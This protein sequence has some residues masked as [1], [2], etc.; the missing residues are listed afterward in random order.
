MPF[1]PYAIYGEEMWWTQSDAQDARWEVKTVH[2]L[3]SCP[4]L[5]V[6]WEGNEVL[7]KLWRYKFD[8]FVDLLGMIFMLKEHLETNQLAMIF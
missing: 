6:I 5:Y 1:L 8:N 7:T 3:L 4:A 2:D